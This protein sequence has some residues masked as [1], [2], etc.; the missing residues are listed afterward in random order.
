[1]AKRSTPQLRL[2]YFGRA[3][4]FSHVAAQHRFPKHELLPCP[5]VESAF[6]SLLDEGVSHIL[7]PIEN[8]SSGIIANTADQLMRLAR[9]DAGAALQIREALVMRIELALMVRADTKTI[10]KIYSHPAPFD[11]SRDWLRKHYPQTEQVVVESTS[12][13]AALAAKEKGAAAIAGQHAAAPHRLKIVSK[14]VGGEVANQ[15]TFIVIGPPLARPSKPTHTSLVFE[16]PHKPGSLVA[17]LHVLSR[18]KLNLTKILSR[19]IP[20]RFEEYRF[21]IEFHGAAPNKK[22]VATLAR[23]NKITDFF[24]IIGSYPV[25]RI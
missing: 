12:E 13:A 10:T 20:G 22:V 9:T 7:V 6:A 4:S 8:A 16:L 24:A 19:P 2:G 23:I 15:T 18:H 5:T 25:R 17:V 14:T 11:H 21:M 1:M 3:G